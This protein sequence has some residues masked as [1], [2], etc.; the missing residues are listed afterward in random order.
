MKCNI[1]RDLL[2]LYCDKLTSQDSNEEIEKHL[3][4]CEE[5]NAVYESMNNKEDII[6]APDKDVKPLKKVKKRFILRAFAIFFGTFAALAAAFV[7]LFVGVIPISS[8]KLHYTA[9]I[10]NVNTYS[11]SDKADITDSNNDGIPDAAEIDSREEL[12]VRI[13]P[14]CSNARYVEH[15]DFWDFS[16]MTNYKLS[17]E[18]Y[19]TFK[20]PFDDR[21]ESPNVSVRGFPDVKEG[22]T[23]TVHCRDKDV[24]IDLWQLWLDT[25]AKE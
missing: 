2:P 16:D 4:E 24:V 14:D 23:I 9:E 8:D 3:H 10:T 1:V 19:P 5:C 18:I 15:R 21:G 12:I 11:W 6:K 17:M 7:F 22:D 25:K 13:M 20:L